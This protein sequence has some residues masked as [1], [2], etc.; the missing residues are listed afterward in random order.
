[1]SRL[2]WGC[3]RLF[4]AFA[5]MAG[6]KQ[7]FAA[8]SSSRTFATGHFESEK[9]QQTRGSQVKGLHYIGSVD[10]SACWVVIRGR[11]CSGNTNRNRSISNRCSAD[12]S[13]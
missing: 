8:D 1:M 11:G 10:R 12:G 5:F 2:F 9:P 3:F 13:V 7:I 6:D 4:I